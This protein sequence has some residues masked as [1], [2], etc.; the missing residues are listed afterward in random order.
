MK[1]TDRLNREWD[2]TLTIGTL[3]RVR[4][5]CGVEL[6][7]LLTDEKSLVSLM[8]EDPERLGIVLYTIV[9]S[10]ATKAN[11]NGESFADGFDGATLTTA[12][13]ALMSAVA[14]F[15]QPPKTCEQVVKSLKAVMESKDELTATMIRNATEKELSA[16]L[17]DTATNSA[18]SAA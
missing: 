14:N 1:F 4:N 11:V 5:A 9:E 10:Q 8:Y 7:K 15:T 2:L 6:G 18:A 16:T 17:S 12:R 13:E 3:T